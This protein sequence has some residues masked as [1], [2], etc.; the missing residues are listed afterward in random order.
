MQD[1]EFIY[2]DN[3]KIKSIKFQDIVSNKRVLFCS[4]TRPYEKMAD[5]Y[6][7]YIASRVEFFKDCG[8]DAVYFVNSTHNKVLLYAYNNRENNTVPLLYDNLKFVN[9]IKK[10][11][12]IITRDTEFLSSYWNFQA[13]F[14]NGVLE[15][16][17]DSSIDDPVK[18]AVKTDPGY[19]K[20]VKEFV[21]YSGADPNLV[22]WVPN[23]W[24][25]SRP[26]LIKL[27]FYNHIWPNTILDQYLLDNKR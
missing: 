23:F 22:L 27:I 11:R 2:L 20:Y 3:G 19:L 1:I 12:N 7:E 4:F 14:N 16:F 15:Y 24:F 17:V 8:I 5:S 13:L 10:Q 21:P 18:D 6:A 9:Y 25:F 26:K